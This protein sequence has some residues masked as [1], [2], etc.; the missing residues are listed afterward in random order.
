MEY[1]WPTAQTLIAVIAQGL[2]TTKSTVKRVSIQIHRSR[3]LALNLA[4][5]VIFLC[6]EELYAVFG[7]AC[8]ILVHLVQDA[9]Q[10]EPR[11]N[12]LSTD[13]FQLALVDSQ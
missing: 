3:C 7:H 9:P 12:T 1:A 13:A 5:L 8:S 10:A 11:N 2:A 4:L 6:I